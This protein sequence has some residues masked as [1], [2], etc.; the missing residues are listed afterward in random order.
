MD[1]PLGEE[2]LLKRGLMAVLAAL[3]A[4]LGAA[5]PV[6]ADEAGGGKNKMAGWPV[7]WKATSPAIH[8]GDRYTLLV[9]NTGEETQEAQVRTV[10]MDHANHTN[11]NVVDEQVELEPGEEREFTADNDYGTANH[12]NTLIG[13]ETQNL[14][15]AVGIADA[16]G[17]ETARFN[18]KAFL[19]QE[20]KGAKGSGAKARAH[21]H[22]EGF[23]ASVPTA[24]WDTARLSP[25]S[26]GVL[27][28]AGF[29][30][31]AAR[32]RWAVPAGGGLAQPIVLP[33][34][35]KA[36]AVGGLASSAALHIGL[37][38]VHFEEATIQG[39]FFSVAGAIT[40]IIA[41][42]ILVWPS[43]LVYLA[44]AGISLALIALWAVFLLVP[45]PGA[46][47]AEGIDLVGL[48]TKATELAALTACT[49]LWFRARHSPRSDRAEP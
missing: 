30:L 43:R 24:L 5:A 38:P 22:D 16:A 21:A 12:F 11:T 14:E 44:G 6:L 17:T 33:P 39:I 45:P 23:A 49:V 32:R 9:T 25:F 41:A 29:G 2:I 31:Y 48:F 8:E 28:V 15:L 10:I 37:A 35:W 40:A 19:I 42:A 13:S 47:A 26:L 27:A 3:V 7:R 36:V 46:E 4:L 20:G 18:E 1:H 34:V